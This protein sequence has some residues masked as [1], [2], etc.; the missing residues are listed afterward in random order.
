MF[1]H[2]NILNS[3]FNPPG[4]GLHVRFLLPVLQHKS[5]G[6]PCEGCWLCWRL[7]AS[8]LSPFLVTMTLLT[9]GVGCAWPA[10]D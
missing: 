9:L 6:L 1:C 4:I 8:L 2:K 7:A 3:L 5:W 10:V